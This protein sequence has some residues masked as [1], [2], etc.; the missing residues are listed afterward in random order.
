MSGLA[1]TA[2]TGVRAAKRIL[3]RMPRDSAL[4]PALLFHAEKNRWFVANGVELFELEHVGDVDVLASV[5]P[6]SVADAD[7][8]SQYRLAGG[9]ARVAVEGDS[10]LTIALTA[11]DGTACDPVTIAYNSISTAHVR[12]VKGA[13]RDSWIAAEAAL[14]L[15]GVMRYSMNAYLPAGPALMP[16]PLSLFGDGVESVTVTLE[17]GAQTTVE[18]TSFADRARVILNLSCAEEPAAGPGLE[19]RA[20]G[21]VLVSSRVNDEPWQPYRREP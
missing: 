5:C 12:W 16:K 13:Y 4:P 2:R 14:T 1:R 10:G 6:L 17:R 21:F 20:L 7:E 11:A 9:T 19:S 8:L 15:D 18:V 3:R